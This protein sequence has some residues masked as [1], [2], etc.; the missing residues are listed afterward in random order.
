MAEETN[1]F[2]AFADLTLDYL[3]G[4][5]GVFYIGYVLA[6]VGYGFTFFQSYF[7]YTRYPNDS[8][9][10]QAAVISLCALD[11]AM[12]ALSSHTL[13]YYLV[14]LFA[15]PVGPEEA[16][17][18]FCV[19]I[20]LSSFVVCIVQSFY[21]VR[22]WQV[23]QS[24]I[25][26]A[27]IIVVSA[28][29]AALGIA[30][31]VVMLGNPSFVNFS[32]Y[33]MEVVISLGQGFRLL[34][35]LMVTGGVL[36][37]GVRPVNSGKFSMWD[38]IISFLTSGMAGAI[39]QFICFV[40]FLAMPKKY[41]WIAF[42]FLSSRVFINGLLLMLNSRTISRGRGIY[43]EETHVTRGITPTNNSRPTGSNL[44]FN[45]SISLNQGNNHTVNIEV[46]RTVQTDREAKHFDQDIDSL[47][48]G[49]DKVDV[50]AF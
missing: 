11:T 33:Y 17:T 50:H 24:A 22:I 7:Y 31:T 21:A 10:V 30:T 26:A 41:L 6:A 39:A 37:Y 48:I 46:S 4:S 38:P 34:S 44:K 14:T 15:L 12:S 18:S 42:H 5:L 25:L 27:A 9:L 40:T 43:E 32:Q 28:A 2:A 20:L 29:G 16:T 23:S 45:T 3:E 47:S 36:V 13:Y 1:P 49:H 19:E 35:A 8:W